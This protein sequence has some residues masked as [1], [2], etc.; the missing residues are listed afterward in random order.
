M[1][2]LINEVAVS[3]RKLW[4]EADIVRK[5]KFLNSGNPKIEMMEGPPFVSGMP[6]MGHLLNWI[7]KD[8]MAKMLKM[9]GYD[10]QDRAG[11]DEHGLPSEMKTIKDHGL[12]NKDV[13][14]M[15]I[16]KFNKLCYDL[17]MKYS[18]QWEP[19]H[20]SI[21]RWIS[22]EDAYHT[23]NPE[24]MESVWYVFKELWEKKLVYHGLRVLSY[25]IGCE[26]PLSNFEAGQSY[27]TIDDDSV[28]VMFKLCDEDRYVVV[29]TTT[30]WTLISNQALAIDEKGDY[31]CIEHEFG[32]G[33]TRNLIVA[34]NGLS[35]VFGKKKVKDLKIID[36]FEGTTLVGKQYEPLHNYHGQT[37][38]TIYSGPFVK[39]T[40]TDPKENIP[41]SG[42]VHISPA[43]GEDDFKL[44]MNVG[45]IDAVGNGIYIT[46]KKDGKFN[47]DIKDI[48]GM[49]YKEAI[50]EIIKDL[51]LKGYF[52]KKETYNHSY[53][54]CPRTGTPLIYMAM[55]SFFIA[56]TMLK[57]Q[58]IEN[59]EKIIWHPDH[60]GKARFGNWLKD[61]K[62][63]GVSRNRKF[64]TPIPVWVSD[65][66]EEMICVG[67]RAELAKLSG[68][69]EKD[70][71]NLHPEFINKIEIPSTMGKGMLKRVSD[72]FDCWFESGSVPF[73][74]HHYPFGGTKTFDGEF[75]ADFI[76]EGIDQTR[77]WF[78]TLMVLSTAL[79]K[80]PAFK[81]VIVTGLVNDKKGE[82]MSKSKGNVVDPQ[83]EIAKYGPDALRLYL[84]GSTATNGESFK[85]DS[86]D[87]EKTNRQLLQFLNAYNFFE[88]FY[89]IFI[90]S[91]GTEID[92]GKYSDTINVTDRWILTRLAKFSEN[93]NVLFDKRRALHIISES[94]RFIDDL[95]NKY[96][97]FNRERMKGRK[98]SEEA[99]KSLRVLWFVLHHF[100]IIMFPV[101]PFSAEYVYQ[102]TKKYSHD[103]KELCIMES[104][105]IDYSHLRYEDEDRAIEKLWN[106][107]KIVRAIRSNNPDI[108]TKKI[109]LKKITMCHNDLSYFDD[110]SAT[111]SYVLEELNV[112]SLSYETIGDKLNYRIEVVKSEINRTFR[113]DAKK[114]ISLIELL[115]SD[116]VNKIRLNSRK[117]F[118]LVDDDKKEYVI[119]EQHYRIYPTLI[120]EN[121]LIMMDGDLV[122]EIEKESEEEATNEKNM[123]LI[124]HGM[125]Q[126]RKSLGLKSSDKVNMYYSS[127][128]KYITSLIIRYEAEIV[129]NLNDKIRP[130][131]HKG[132]GLYTDEEL[133][134]SEVRLGE[135]LI[136]N[137]YVCQQY[138]DVE[139]E[140]RKIKSMEASA[141]VKD[142]M[143]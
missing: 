41:G 20:H 76:T 95:T 88:E 112:K 125:N 109:P 27:K 32:D 66:G 111:E 8:W 91:T 67:S 42:I 117:S 40:T 43:Y 118:V 106:I 25:S 16:A 29:W 114:V 135:S 130:I 105:L 99:E 103:G 85:Y 3:S 4:D 58:L 55:P 11:F 124:V 136:V 18:R 108:S 37:S 56:V 126:L 5:V 38:F 60:V 133:G 68:I 57:D 139:I 110:I 74:Q 128:D 28:F 63:W 107:A 65:D 47:D 86:E 142:A 12:S 23:A 62:D 134:S 9:R 31:V 87:V 71:I 113:H 93:V 6:H 34:K 73:A 19:I 22:Y 24:F 115:K 78:Y 44:A 82:K 64:G 77:G 121:S 53:P 21:G 140:S 94:F 89:D 123:R 119:E 81:E 2:S 52:F 100:S 96:I 141:S 49:F 30:P 75:P 92:F 101:I 80:K 26:T 138:A 10:V 45:L 116:D 35:N 98:G 131:E 46:L 1:S 102:E 69:D 14:D 61:A 120:E 84:L 97:Q 48:G 59:N 143:A 70:I 39:T 137:L 51:K 50:P 129:A 13:D 36:S 90:S 33:S 127:H 72:V 79:L 7:I 54:H 83:E 15:G 122:I 104:H 17:V 132:R